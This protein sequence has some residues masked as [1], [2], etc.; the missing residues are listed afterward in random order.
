MGAIT[1]PWKADVVLR[2]LPPE[3][4]A[5]FSEPGYVKISWTL[6]VD[7]TGPSG[8]VFRTETRAI[9]TDPESRSRF[10]RYWAFLSPGILLIRYEMLRLL[11]TEAERRHASRPKDGPQSCRRLRGFGAI[12]AVVQAPGLCACSIR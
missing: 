9:A 4:F 12:L 10:R 2:A 3:K 8:C 1:Q 11:V 5:A 6:R 7:P